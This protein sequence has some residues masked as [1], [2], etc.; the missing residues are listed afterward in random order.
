MSDRPPA[1]RAAIRARRA[2]TLGRPVEALADDALLLSLVHDSF[3]LVEMVIDLQDAFGV[4]LVQDD[5][6]DVKSVAV[7]LNVIEARL[8]R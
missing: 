6:K 1:D 3:V 2:R 5:L 8:D 7:L 4:R